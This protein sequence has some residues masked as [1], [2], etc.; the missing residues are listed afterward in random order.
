[1]R[2]PYLPWKRGRTWHY[3]LLD[4]KHCLSTGQSTRSAAEQFVIELIYQER[5][6]V[7]RCFSFRRYTEPFFM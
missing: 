5:G 4:S 3:K 6:S 7:P 1:M 2:R